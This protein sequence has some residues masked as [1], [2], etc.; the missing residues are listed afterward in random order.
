MGEC[1]FCKIVN[2]EIP[3]E[4]VYENDQIVAFKDINPVAPVHILIVPKVHVKSI[5]ELD[6]S[7]N[8]LNGVAEAIQKIAKD[9]NIACEGFRVVNNC[10]TLAGQSVDHLHFHLLG[11]RAMQWPPG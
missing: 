2:K 3:S 10:G 6:T 7:S 4:I 8:I 5:M 1:I 9:Q 11:G